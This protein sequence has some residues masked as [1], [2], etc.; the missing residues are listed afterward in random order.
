MA[1]G[2]A[3]EDLVTTVGADAVVDGDGDVVVEAGSG[4]VCDAVVAVAT[5]DETVVPDAPTGP[6]VVQPARPTA[7]AAV[8]RMRA[9]PRRFMPGPGRLVPFV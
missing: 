7:A 2:G 3:E 5:G 9:D 8:S 6:V 1:P 4:P